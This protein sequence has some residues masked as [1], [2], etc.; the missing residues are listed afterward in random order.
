MTVQTHNA[1]FIDGPTVIE[2]NI[3][4]P[5]TATTVALV[6]AS[7]MCFDVIS[8]AGTIAA[9]TLTVANGTIA[10]QR[11][12]LVFTQIVTALT[13]SG[14]NLSATVLAF[15]TASAANQ[16]VEFIWSVTNSW[17]IRVV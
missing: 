17:W 16:V 10:G 13:C 7:M 11:Q 6:P 3:Y 15:P 2:P 14:A 1:M 5:L 4:T 9:L 12:R 8:P